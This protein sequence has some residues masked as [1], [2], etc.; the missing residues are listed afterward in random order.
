[1]TTIWAVLISLYNSVNIFLE[2]NLI[3]SPLFL[4]EIL[5]GSTLS[6]YEGD[7][8]VNNSLYSVSVRSCVTRSAS[9]VLPVR[10]G[11]TNSFHTTAVQHFVDEECTVR[12]SCL[13]DEHGVHSH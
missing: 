5:T 8:T 6:R 12:E 4:Q 3:F 7:N 13:G 2:A 1:M 9:A 10:E 11:T